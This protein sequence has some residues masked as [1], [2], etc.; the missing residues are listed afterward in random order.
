MP[1][2]LEEQLKRRTNRHPEWSKERKNRYIYH[3]LDV[4]EQRHKTK[5]ARHKKRLNLANRR[6]RRRSK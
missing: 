6:R 1:K 5:V 3:T 4:V 2:E